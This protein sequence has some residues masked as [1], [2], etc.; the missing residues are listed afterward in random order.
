MVSS[1][2]PARRIP[3]DVPSS[4]RS[5]KMACTP[6]LDV[7]L[8]TPGLSSRVRYRLLG[9]AGSASPPLGLLHLASALAEH[10]VKVRVVDGQQYGGNPR[11]VAARIA[12]LG[13]V[14]VGV[15]ATT[16]EYP[17]ARTLIAAVRERLPGAAIVGGGPHFSAL[18]ARSL[19]ENPGLDFVVCGEGEECMCSLI[20][21]RGGAA[22][23]RDLAGLHTRDGPAGPF[24]RTDCVNLDALPDLDWTLLDGRLSRYHIQAQ[25]RATGAATLMSSRGCPHRCA[26]CSNQ[27]MGSRVR[28]HSASYIHRQMREL[29]DRYGVRH[30][31][32]EDDTFFASRR[33][34]RELLPL[35]QED[36]MPRMTWSCA[37]S[38]CD[39][40]EEELEA[41]RRA[42]CT[43]VMYGVETAND[44]LLSRI[45]KRLT[46]AEARQA[47]E[48]TRRAGLRSKA[49]FIIG[50]PG[51]T[52][53]T[54]AD[55][56][57][58]IMSADID[59]ISMK[60][61]T[62]YPGSRAYRELEARGAPVDR[63]DAMNQFR[64]T[65]VPVGLTAADMRRQMCRCMAG[66]YFRR[67][68]VG[69]YVRS[70]RAVRGGIRLA[71]SAVALA[72]F[73]TVERLSAAL[74]KQREDTRHRKYPDSHGCGSARKR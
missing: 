38:V 22:A 35:L 29:Y 67:Q 8:A 56:Y 43:Y 3:A 51:E 5:L 49:F 69:D 31:Q 18:P 11:R 46:V 2:A 25:S 70:M 6:S 60:Y 45:G 28:A 4:S 39:V 21:G 14:C 26:F 7:V 30:V 58:F 68:V 72:A 16:L 10:G 62:P 65:Y 36:G 33:R 42:G 63:W 19:A 34:N 41:A 73:L 15:G 13:A 61:F 12:E 47:L 9:P 20:A 52:R 54:M 17:G 37:T 32:F 66:F 40:R 50:L 53:R 71:R 23:P 1:Q 59:D 48:M 55:T 57:D 24:A 44:H 64:P 27:V 74:P